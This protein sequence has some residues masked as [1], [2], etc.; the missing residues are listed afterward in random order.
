MIVALLVV[1]LAVA[2]KAAGSLPPPVPSIESGNLHQYVQ[3]HGEALF[4]GFSRVRLANVHPGGAAAV[5]RELVEKSAR[6][7]FHNVATMSD[8]QKFKYL[9]GMHRR[10]TEAEARGEWQ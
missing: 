6:S 4:E 3:D 9:S 2:V 8:A 5:K 10:A 7:M 1:A